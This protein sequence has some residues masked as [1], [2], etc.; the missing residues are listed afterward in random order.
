MISATK[1]LPLIKAPRSFVLPKSMARKPASRK[2][3][4]DWYPALRLATS[5]AVI[6]LV[7]VFAGDVLTPRA[8]I[9]TTNI[10]TSAGAPVSIAVVP[11]QS[12]LD[13]A[14]PVAPAIAPVPNPQAGA[15]ILPTATALADASNVAVFAQPEMTSTQAVDTATAKI[16][17]DTVTQTEPMSVSVAFEAGTPAADEAVNGASIARAAD[18]TDQ[19]LQ[20]IGP[21]TNP[22]R[23]IELILAGLVIALIAATFI[24]RQRARAR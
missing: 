18:Q 19:Q 23:T 1:S 20:P 10:P 17:A 14:P 13:V 9:V 22:L 8:T 4:F 15:G 12:T 24:A 2:S 5:I 16:A 11:T 21:T 7:L 3:I 6:A